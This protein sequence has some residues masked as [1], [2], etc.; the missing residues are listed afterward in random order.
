MSVDHEILELLNE[1]EAILQSV[2]SELKKQTLSGTQR[3]HVEAAKAR[4]LTARIVSTR[5]DEDKQ[6]IASDEAVAHRLTGM[7]RDELESISR[8]GESP[9]FARIVLEEE[10]EGQSP[11][12]IEY[13]IGR[14]S[15]IDCRIVD[16]RKAPISRLYYEYREG[17][18]YCEVIQGRE[19][20][21]KILLRR[22]VQIEEGELK[23]VSCIAGDFV[24]EGGEWNPAQG[25]RKRGPSGRLPDVLSLIT[26]EQFKAITSDAD[27]AVLL[28]GVAGSGK[29]TVALHRL[30]WLLHQ[31]DFDLRKEN[32]IVLAKSRVLI[33]YIAASLQELGLDGVT[34]ISYDEWLEKRL[35]PLISPVTFI[36]SADEDAS[37]PLGALRVLRSRALLEAIEQYAASQRERV[38]MHL[39]ERFPWNRVEN[40]ARRLFESFRSTDDGV[41]KLIDDLLEFLKSPTLLDLQEH[42]LSLKRRLTLYLED[43]E[44]VLKNASAIVSA[45]ETKLLDVETVIAIAA[46]AT[47]RIKEDRSINEL[48]APLIYYLAQLKLKGSTSGLAD[49][50]TVDETQD[51]SAAELATI[52]NSANGER[53]LTLA[54]DAAQAVTAGTSFIGWK[55]LRE[56]LGA[57]SS[58]YISLTVSHRSTRTIMNLAEF[59]HGERR[60]VS[61]RDGSKPVWYKCFTEDRAMRETIGW[62][63][64]AAESDPGAITAVLCRSYSEAAHVHSLLKPAFGPAVHLWNNSSFSFEEGIVVSP[65]VLTKGLEFPRVLIWN[66]SASAYPAAEKARRVLYV[67]LTRAEDELALVTFDKPSPLLPS[68]YSKL[69]DCIE[70]EA[71]EESEDEGES[72]EFS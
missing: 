50:V 9:Y 47:N 11:K 66:P 37:P 30:S 23:H 55:K 20:T 19:R 72:V 3:L 32:S 58:R 51:F 6:L 7:K 53:G 17:D 41:L 29:T 38:I 36:N 4:D 39:G 65:V 48:E 21:G 70:E 8:L 60:A 64:K 14:E 12:R 57:G 1:E 63:T 18:E 24:K 28:E 33:A 31:K 54:G 15:N 34:V 71:D 69:I 13:K 67:A 49:S 5:R 56:H 16:W 44:L 45:D 40:Q 68:P 62:L 61:G 52:I 46:E 42:L 22:R 2:L 43:F 25:R 27:A 59:V 10:V 35:A 26:K